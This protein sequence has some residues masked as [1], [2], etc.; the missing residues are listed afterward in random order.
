MCALLTV[1]STVRVFADSAVAVV[2]FLTVS[3]G[4]FVFV[5]PLFWVFSDSIGY[6]RRIH[7]ARLCMTAAWWME[8]AWRGAHII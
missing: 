1:T 2:V 7:C 4:A 5:L 6:E 8:M 3:G